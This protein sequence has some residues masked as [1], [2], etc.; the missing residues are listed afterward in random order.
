M[1]TVQEVPL[2]TIHRVSLHFG[3]ELRLFVKENYQ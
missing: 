2:A 3:G 1:L